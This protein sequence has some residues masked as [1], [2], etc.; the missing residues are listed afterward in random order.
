MLKRISL[1]VLV[2]ALVAA[3]PAS[4]ALVGSASGVVKDS[5]GAALPG[6]SVTLTGP[7]LQ[8]TRSSVTRADGSWRL[9]NLPAGDGY[10]AAF[11]LSGFKTVNSELFAVRIDLDTQVHATMQLTDVKGEIVVTAE[12]PD[13][14]VTQT[15]NQQNFSSEYLKKIPIGSANRSYQSIP[16][17]SAGVVGAGNPSTAGT[18]SRTRSSWTASTR[19]TR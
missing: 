10:K 17:Q 15:T 9:F 18:S 16:A 6:A 1:V 13:V 11:Q 2:L 14:D 4:A 5:A 7:A 8:G 12:A 3:V 19:P